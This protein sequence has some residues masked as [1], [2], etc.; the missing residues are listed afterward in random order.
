MAGR[1]TQRSGARSP[2]EQ[3]FLAEYDASRFPHPSVAVDVALIHA[4]QGQLRALLLQRAEHP[5]RGRWSLPG[6]F[7]RPEESL[8]QA[9]ARALLEKAGL[10]G[11]FLEQLYTFGEPD[12]DPRT[13]VITVAYYALVDT[14]RLPDPGRPGK[15]AKAPAAARQWAVLDVPWEGERGGPIAAREEE[16]GQLELAFDHDEILGLAVQRL[17]G[18]LCYAPI[19][20]ELLPARFTLRQLQD[21]HETILGRPHNKD[22]F[23]RSML[24]SGL[25]VATGKRESDVGHRPAELYRFKRA[26]GNR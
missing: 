1:K 16:G 2:E 4:Q 5:D 24:A 19:G 7:V 3:Q 11:I 8:D 15:S 22:S 9:A 14:A 13:R 25:I 23:R 6:T 20:F 21:I 18:K 10:S 17:R 26:N 12:R